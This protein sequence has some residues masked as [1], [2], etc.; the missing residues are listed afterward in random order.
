MWN[1]LD[2]D[3]AAREAHAKDPKAAMKKFGLTA[4]EQAALMSGDKKKVADLVGFLLMRSQLLW[5]M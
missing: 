4:E 1:T 2:K 3:A 5:S